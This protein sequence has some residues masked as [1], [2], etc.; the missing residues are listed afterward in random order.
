MFR[1]FCY[2]KNI[3]GSH[4]KL[5]SVNFHVITTENYL[6]DPKDIIARVTYGKRNVWNLVAGFNRLP[7]SRTRYQVV[8]GTKLLQ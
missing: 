4:E 6:E 7:R 8:C 2:D 1:P 3:V 5:S